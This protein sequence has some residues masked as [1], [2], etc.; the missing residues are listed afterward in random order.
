MHVNFGIMPPLDA[1][2]RNKR[3]RYEAYAERGR[4]ALE[5]YREDLCRAGLEGLIDG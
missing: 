3:K 2:V 4:L 5:G 1:P